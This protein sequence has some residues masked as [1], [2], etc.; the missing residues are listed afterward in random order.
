MIEYKLG[1]DMMDWQSLL[2]MYCAVD[3]V[4]GLAK[5][6]ELSIIKKS[7]LNTYKVVT[8]WD[9]Q[10]IIGAGRMISD[11]ECYGWIHDIG[12]LPTYQKKGIGKH[13]M[14]ELM[15]DETLLF[16][17]TSSFV[18]EEFYQKLGFKKHKTAMAKYPGNSS[19]LEE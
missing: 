2:E 10:R 11:G 3:G 9:G 19:Y 5:K 16:G 13:I 4:I 17:L 7:F 14:D 8:A 6:G 12:V 18:A 1:T 15:K